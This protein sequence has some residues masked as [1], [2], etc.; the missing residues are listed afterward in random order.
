MLTESLEK[1][2]VETALSLGFEQVAITDRLTIE[3]GDSFDAWRE[4]SRHGAMRYMENHRDLRLSER[5]IEPWVRSAIVCLTRYPAPLDLLPGGLRIARY[6]HG[7]DYHDVLRARSTAL[8]DAI[9]ELAGA[10]YRVTVDTAPLLERAFAHAAGLGWIGKNAMLIHPTSGSFTFISQI[11]TDLELVSAP[12][13]QPD[14]CGTCSACLDQCPTGAIVSPQVIDARRCIAYWTIEHRGP[15]PREL[16][17]LIGDFWFGCDL[18]QDVCPWNRKP[19]APEDAQLSTRP[20]Y[21]Q[22]TPVDILEMTLK[23]YTAWFRHSAI[24]RA[25][26]LGLL[27]NAAVVL[28]NTGRGLQA[29]VRQL[30]SQPDAMVRGHIVW[31]LGQFDTDVARDALRAHVDLDPF[32]N[33]ELKA[34]RR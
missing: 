4:E 25:T 14:R 17:P 8:A 21:L 5:A 10:Q 3:T 19:V 16:R 7:D 26:Y 12:T 23:Q 2:I 15:I 1:R 13:R 22:L 20:H 24:K 27:R 31:A 18:C 30:A 11:W 6:A 28:G 29:L 32:V 9:G 33:E 34:L